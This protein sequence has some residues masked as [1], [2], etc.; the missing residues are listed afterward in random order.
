MYIIHMRRLSNTPTGLCFQPPE[1]TSYP[2]CSAQG[3]VD[4]GEGSSRSGP[5]GSS[6]CSLCIEAAA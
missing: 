6:S 1:V 3:A 5:C 4:I 2:D